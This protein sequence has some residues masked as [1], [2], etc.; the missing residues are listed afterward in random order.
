MGAR[1]AR[2]GGGAEGG[3]FADGD[4]KRDAK[5]AALSAFLLSGC[6]GGRCYP[7]VVVAASKGN[8]VVSWMLQQ[9]QRLYAGPAVLLNHASYDAKL[10]YLQ[11]GRCS[12]LVLCVFGM[13]GGAGESAAAIHARLAAFTEARRSDARRET[14]PARE[15]ARGEVLLYYNSADGHRVPESLSA[16][17]NAALPTLVRGAVWGH[18]DKPALEAGKAAAAL[19]GTRTLERQVRGAAAWG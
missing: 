7:D 11:P 14:D 17:G 5:R 10:D 19:V 9:P 4:A 18:A 16:W 15:E 12:R 2:G 6:G 1:G 13:D 8:A 3:T